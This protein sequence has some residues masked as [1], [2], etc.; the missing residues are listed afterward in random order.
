M[1][2]LYLVASLL[3]VWGSAEEI[4]YD[5]GHSRLTYP[6]PMFDYFACGRKAKSY[7]CDPD[8]VISESEGKLLVVI[9]L[10]FCFR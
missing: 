8:S 1:G 7:I 9:C 10:P 4:I 2:F 5:E 6:D 3:F